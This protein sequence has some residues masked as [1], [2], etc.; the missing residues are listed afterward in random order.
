MPQRYAF[1]ALFVFGAALTLA[2][3]DDPKPTPPATPA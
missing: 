2:L 1:A 3:A